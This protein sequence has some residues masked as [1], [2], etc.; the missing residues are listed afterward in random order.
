MPRTVIICRALLLCQQQD[1]SIHRKM[2]NRFE[3]TCARLFK[4][5]LL[6]YSE[7]AFGI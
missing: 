5:H 7:T 2:F 4:K 3:E 6:F 1:P